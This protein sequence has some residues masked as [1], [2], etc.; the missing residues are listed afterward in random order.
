M[1]M[2]K[3]VDSSKR[4]LFQAKQKR[5]FKSIDNLDAVRVGRRKSATP[6]QRI[7]YLIKNQRAY[8]ATIEALK[9][10][11]A[12][13][14]EV[15]AKTAMKGKLKTSLKLKSQINKCDDLI[16]R[17]EKFKSENKTLLEDELRKN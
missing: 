14:K 16:K 12:R 6:D 3:I 7:S 5:M 2:G 1:I 17:L 8:E 13:V 11:K 9:A 15:L 10:E 4:A